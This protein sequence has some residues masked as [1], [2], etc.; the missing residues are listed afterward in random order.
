[1]VTREHLYLLMARCYEASQ[2]L[3]GLQMVDADRSNLRD[4]LIGFAETIYL[5]NLEK[6]NEKDRNTH[7]Q[8]AL[9]VTELI[10][11]L[12]EFHTNPKN[13]ELQ[14]V[15]TKL[16]AEWGI[17]PRYN[18]ILFS[19]GAYS[20]R[21]FHPL[22]FAWLQSYYNRTFSKIP[23]VVNLPREYDG[24]ILF[25]SVVFHEVGHMVENDRSLGG[26]VYD[27]LIKLIRNP[28]ATVLKNYFRPDYD[29]GAL[30]EDRIRA[31]IKEYIAD[32]F[33]AQYMRNHILHFLNCHES[34][35][36]DADT[37][38]HPSFKCREKFVKSF[39]DCFSRPSPDTSDDLLRTIIKVFQNEGA[40]PD[41]CL[42][43]LNLDEEEIIRGNST[44]LASTQ[45]MFSIFS[46]AWRASLKG[47]GNAE[48]VRG[49]EH[50]SLSRYEFYSSINNATKRSITGF[51]ANNP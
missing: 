48:T 17:D 5:F 37:S 41:L 51:M 33:G 47:I 32:V 44:V 25:S 29:K 28:K 14:Y 40:I 8:L 36:Q 18:I 12:I 24:D 20:V 46:S 23:R 7:A 13:R 2:R 27:E 38:D 26:K 19:Q 49:M 31:Y 16:A 34:L 30:V 43:D 35:R 6:S 50:G 1:M 22:V 3:A 15:V 4:D 39:L 42:R 11:Y 10:S 21:H 9:I 45:E